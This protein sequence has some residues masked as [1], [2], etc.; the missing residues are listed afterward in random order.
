MNNK[1]PRLDS[2]QLDNLLKKKCLG[3]Y[4]STARIR[5]SG[6]PPVYHEVCL[7]TLMAAS[8]MV[9]NMTKYKQ[10]DTSNGIVELDFSDMPGLRHD[11]FLTVFDQLKPFPESVIDKNNVLDS[12]PWHA[13][14][15]T[16]GYEKCDWLVAKTINDNCALIYKHPMSTKMRELIDEVIEIGRAA[17]EHSCV[18]GS[19]AFESFTRSVA[20]K[21]ENPNI[22]S[23]LSV[24][25]WTMLF[26]VSKSHKAIA[27]DVLQLLNDL[28]LTSA[29]LDHDIFD[30]DLLPSLTFL[31]IRDEMCMLAVDRIVRSDI[32]ASRKEAYM[33]QLKEP[34]ELIKWN[35]A[36]FK[37]Y[38]H[39]RGHRHSEHHNVVSLL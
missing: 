15:I 10:V 39:T 5:V 19:N 33:S 13:F 22:A 6:N 25:N 11:Y 38:L 7:S 1:K 14:L 26:H 18:L 34:E 17:V 9:R 2:D 29:K 3:E 20:K 21:S 37:I 36:G 35:I 24:E 31:K 16:K 32:A 23:S 28:Q 8:E 4:P 27:A 30:N 12:L